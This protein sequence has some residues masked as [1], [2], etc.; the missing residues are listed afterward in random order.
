MPASA[1]S[2]GSL[3]EALEPLYRG[4]LRRLEEMVSRLPSGAALTERTSRDAEGRLVLG[5]AGLPVRF[6]VADA[7]DGHTWEVHGARPDEPAASDVRVGNL[8]VRL[9]PGNWEE[10]P[11][12]C[13]FERDPSPE[14][15]E[16]LADLLRGF[17]TLAWHGGFA[18][19]QPAKGRWLGRAHGIQVELRGRE[20]WAVLDLGT[21]PPSAVE[22]LCAALSGYGEVRAP[23][24]YV[25]MGGKP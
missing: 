19:A 8:E 14:E 25:R 6:D 9:Q 1:G 7:R 16:E 23:L 18:A 22:S 15:V 24:S 2:S 20:L 13:A 4:Y 17:T 21:C 12:V 5:S 11:V 10:L 3:S